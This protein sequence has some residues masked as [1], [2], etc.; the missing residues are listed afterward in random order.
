MPK[1]KIKKMADSET[2]QWFKNSIMASPRSCA[3]MKEIVTYY[4]H[5]R[6]LKARHPDIHQLREAENL[7]HLIS[8]AE[9]TFKDAK[10]VNGKELFEYA[11]DTKKYR[12]MDDKPKW[13]TKHKFKVQ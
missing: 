13:E 3:K 8:V 6:I 9:K 7:L 11:D 5:K 2:M 12:P 4:L 10:I 1:D